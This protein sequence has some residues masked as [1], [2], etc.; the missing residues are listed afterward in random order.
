MRSRG[1][2]SAGPVT[3]A[4]V[5]ARP[6]GPAAATG[7]RARH[8]RVAGGPGRAHSAPRPPRAC[9]APRQRG[10]GECRGCGGRTRVRAPSPPLAPAAVAG[11][12]RCWLAVCMTVGG[13]GGGFLSKAK[14]PRVLLGRERPRPPLRG[15]WCAWWWMCQSTAAQRFTESQDCLG[16]KGH[17][18]ITQGRLEQMAQE[19]VPPE[20]ETP[21]PP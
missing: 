8:F 6:P 5:E 4:G 15:L 21:Q 1:T 9:A 10:P 17:L 18:E 19:R 11:G 3:C 20:R 2:R 13:S 16:W 12:C 7:P 14:K